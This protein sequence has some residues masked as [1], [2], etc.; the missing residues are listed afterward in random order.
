[1]STPIR[2]ALGALLVAS[3]AAAQSADPAL[4]SSLP[5]DSLLHNP[6]VAHFI[7][8]FTGPA[9][10]RM[11]AWLDRGS[12]YR[13][14]IRDRLKGQGLPTE[15][16]FLP[17]IESGY[18]STAVSKAGAV[19][20]WQFIPETAKRMGLSI[21]RYVDERRDPYLATDAAVKHIADLSR[22][23]GSPLLAAAAYNGGAG[24][25]ERGLAKLYGDAADGDSAAGSDADFF[26]LADRKLLASETRD[27]VPQLI[28]AAAIGRDPERFGF[29]PL[30]LSR[31]EF[32]SL[33]VKGPMSLGAAARS[34]GLPRDSLKKLNPQYVRGVTP[35]AATSWVRVPPG[36]GA[37]LDRRLA[38]LPPV[39]ASELGSPRLGFGKL[40]RVGK[41]DT[42]ES[43]AKEHGLTPEALRRAN[44]IPKWYRLRPGM[45]LRLPGSEK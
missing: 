9:R 33:S 29:T 43:L 35:P 44:A 7:E 26:T 20:M 27:Y 1:M 4:G 37:E 11:A 6:R 28:A 39:T 17:L 8:L 13:G 19:G 10:D 31:P 3:P 25:V 34:L 41:G 16:E 42:V 30:P 12:A 40:I 22:T 36:L 32:D 18:S 24:R 21:N 2:L 38:S 14:L 15:L 5:I 23:L 45:A